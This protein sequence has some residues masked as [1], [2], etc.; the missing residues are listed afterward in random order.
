L[1][2]GDHITHSESV[3]ESGSIPFTGAA[4]KKDGKF[5]QADGGT[6]FL[7]EIAD[8]PLDLQAKLL[9]VIQERT[10]ESLG[11]RFSRKI[12]VR[13][14]SASHQNLDECVAAGKFRQDLKFRILVADVHLPPLRERVDD[15]EL[16][17]G[18]FTAV[19]NKQYKRTCY[20]QKQTLKILKQYPWPGNV[21]ELA[22]IVEKHII[23]AEGPAICYVPDNRT[24]FDGFESHIT[25]PTLAG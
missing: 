24:Q 2:R 22:G 3:H 11:S 25:E 4:D 10:V 5:V 18:H 23:Q 9:R 14:I 20:F 6:I 19:Y 8:M 12:N 15:I 21:R 13:I 17:V 16:L 1:H 7:D